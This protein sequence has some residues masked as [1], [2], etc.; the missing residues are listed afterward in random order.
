MQSGGVS[1]LNNCADYSKEKKT[2]RFVKF[3]SYYTTRSKN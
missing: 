2:R 1:F 3:Y